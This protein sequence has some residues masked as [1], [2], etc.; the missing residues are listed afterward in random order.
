MIGTWWPVS[1][2]RKLGFSIR[3][4][5]ASAA[6]RVIVM[7]KSVAAK[8]SSASTN[9]LPFQK[10]SSRSSIAIEPSPWGLSSATRW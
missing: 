2:E 7:M 9:S 3:C 1:V 10:L 4:A 5:D 8:P 6:D